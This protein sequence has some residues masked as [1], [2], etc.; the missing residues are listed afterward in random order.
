MNSNFRNRRTQQNRTPKLKFLVALCFIALLHSCKSSQD[1]SSNE[2]TAD[3]QVVP[4]DYQYPEDE[5]FKVLSWNVEHFVDAYDDP[6]IDASREND[7]TPEMENKLAYLA[8][9]LKN[10][11][12]DIIVLQEFESTKFLRE[13]AKDH[14][15]GMGYEFFASAP[16]DG[17]Y[18]NVVLM[19]K[20]PLGILY[21][22]GNVTTPVV[23]Y[24]NDEGLSET[25]NNLNTRMWSIEVF[26]SK[27]YDFILTGLHLKAGRGERNES[28]RLGQ[29]NFLKDQFSRFVDRNA[30]QDLLIAGD[31]NSTL[32][33]QEIKT[34]KRGNTEGNS[35]FDPLPEEV[36]THPSDQP[37]RR[38]DYI[39]FNGNMQDEYIPGTAKVPELLEDE[40][41]QAVSDHLPIVIQ[42]K[43]SNR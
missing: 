21:A 20:F 41:M 1:I 32:G 13:I 26:P 27:D 9:A 19:S 24:K 38:L 2:S 40:K 30:S 37:S 29:I 31:L 3:P 35:F 18:M 43:K 10:A 15:T 14:L 39:L 5:T 25:Q 8:E 34:L 16:S 22:Y 12:A 33:S 17:W 36:L 28:M 23:D 11:D 6:Y 7:P 42:F 4:A